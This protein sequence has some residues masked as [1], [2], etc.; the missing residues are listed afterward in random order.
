MR[1][2]NP[3]PKFSILF[4]VMV[5]VMDMVSVRVILDYNFTLV[6]AQHTACLAWKVEL[7]E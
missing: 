5:M 7:K 3:G 2:G 6:F 4:M 1:V